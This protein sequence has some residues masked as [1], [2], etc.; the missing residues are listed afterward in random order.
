MKTKI[1][2][3]WATTL[4]GLVIAL[5]ATESYFQIIGGLREI[6]LLSYIGLVSLGMIVMLSTHKG[7]L[8][9]LKDVFTNKKGG[10]K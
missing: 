8:T 2:K 10:F 5:I 6:D 1:F 4:F 9:F 3:N 7:L